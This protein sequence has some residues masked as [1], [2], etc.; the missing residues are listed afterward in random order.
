MDNLKNEIFMELLQKGID[1][2]LLS[3]IINSFNTAKE[4]YEKIEEITGIKI[5]NK[6]QALN[7]KKDKKKIES[8]KDLLKQIPTADS[9]DDIKI[10]STNQNVD[11][12]EKIKEENEKNPLIV[13][14]ESSDSFSDDDDRK[15]QKEKVSHPMIIP[16]K[17]LP[18][19]TFYHKTINDYAKRHPESSNFKIPYKKNINSVNFLLANNAK[20]PS[21]FSHFLNTQ[22]NKF[23]DPR[24]IPEILF[25]KVIKNNKTVKSDKTNLPPEN[26]IEKPQPQDKNI[27]KNTIFKL[28]E[29]AEE[30][31]KKLNLTPKNLICTEPSVIFSIEI[32]TNSINDLNY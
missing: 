26:I 9:K 2:E 15:K 25:K 7:I 18:L 32:F 3:P 6:H 24:M 17:S 8:S 29:F 19:K 28:L 5:E 23:S 4:I 30:Q 21:K 22:S 16:K 20:P 13:E 11:K 27:S 10:L 12:I 31:V 1:S 14:E